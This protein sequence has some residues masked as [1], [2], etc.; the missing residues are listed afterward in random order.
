[1]PPRAAAI[2]RAALRG[3]ASS[4][5]S[6]SRLISSPT[7]KKKIAISPSLTHSSSGFE[8]ANEPAPTVTTVSHRAA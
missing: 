3:S 4:P 2:A 8:I 7:T 1:M 6:T 5:V